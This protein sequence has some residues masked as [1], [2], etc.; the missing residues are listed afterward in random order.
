MQDPLLSCQRCLHHQEQHDGGAQ[1]QSC[2]KVA[3]AMSDLNE[4]A[5]MGQ[6]ALP[7]PQCSNTICSGQAYLV[8][9]QKGEQK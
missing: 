4:A 6:A 3:H 5:E 7:S 8:L 9:S 1:R 2:Y